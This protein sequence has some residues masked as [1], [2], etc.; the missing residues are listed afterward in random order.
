LFF[1]YRAQIALYR[2][3]MITIVVCLLCVGL[4]TAQF[5]NQRSI[6]QSTI[7]Y[8]E[9]QH[10]RE[11][12]EML[13]SMTGTVDLKTCVQLMLG[14]Y[15]AKDEK[16]ELA[17]LTRK[18]RDVAGVAN[19]DPQSYYGDILRNAY[20]S[21]RREVPASLSARLWY[22]P[23][24]WNVLRML[25]ASVAHGSWAHLIG[26]LL[27]FFAF[28]ATIEILLGPLLYLAVLLALAL[29]THSVYSLAMVT[30]PAPL[31]TLG[32]SGVVMGVIALFAYFL[33][34]AKIRCFLWLVVLY[35]RFGVPAWL[36]ATWYIGWDVYAQLTGDG[37]SRVNLVAHLSGAALGLSIGLVF[38]RA[39]RHWAQELVQT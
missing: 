17:S 30:Q 19:A 25:S 37:N 10:D 21:Y 26:N 33:P 34:K 9:R 27:F 14:L 8:C 36:L 11:F 28:A 12:R 22:P 31:P 6:I 39:K 15:H 35:R 32:L 24:S 20:Q 7:T 4:Y 13:R 5:L 3:P 38:F 29:G 16:A 2:L 18:I 23:A 1:P